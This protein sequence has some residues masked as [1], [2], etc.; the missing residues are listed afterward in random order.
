MVVRKGDGVGG[1]RVMMKEEP[2]KKVMKVR[3]VSNSDGSC[4][5]F[6]KGCVETDLWECSA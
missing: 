4:V 1:V 6:L 2:C 3:K 5:G